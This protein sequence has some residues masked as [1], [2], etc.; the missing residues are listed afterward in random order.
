MNYKRIKDLLSSVQEYADRYSGCKKVNVGSAI[1]IN[2]TTE[3]VIFGVNR[4][5]PVSCKECGCQRE[6][7]YGED[8]KNHRLPSDCRAL[9]SEI[10]A[11]TCAAKM[12]ISV[13]NATIL[14]T[15]YPCEACA[16]AIVNSGI[17]AVYYGRQQEISEQTKSIFEKA[18]VKVFWVK[19]WNYEDTTR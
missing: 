4:T 9:H 17:K 5:L 15:R 10:E 19:D 1:L 7:L 16:R 3:T 6:K 18:E 2:G 14:V 12:G 11:L 8:S 13:E